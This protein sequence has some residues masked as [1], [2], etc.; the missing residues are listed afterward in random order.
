MEDL[1]ELLEK[2]TEGSRE[3]DARIWCEVGQREFKRIDE[4]FVVYKKGGV[5]YL[6]LSHIPAYTTSV[7]CALTLV[8]DGMHKHMGDEYGDN[9]GGAS[10]ARIFPPHNQRNGTGNQWARTLPLAL[11]IATLR[12]R[13]K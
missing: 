5:G 3:L 12:A 6:D 8:P 4:K 1:I 11:C 9:R 10:W 7:D 13:G 2:A